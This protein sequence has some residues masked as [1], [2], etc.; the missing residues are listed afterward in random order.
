M[1]AYSCRCSWQISSTPYEHG[2]P[3]GIK[4][5]KDDEYECDTDPEASDKRH[6]D[7]SSDDDYESPG[8]APDSPDAGTKTSSIIDQRPMQEKRKLPMSVRLAKTKEQIR[9]KYEAYKREK[10]EKRREKQKK[11]LHDVE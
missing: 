1:Y 2:T 4:K 8:L 7:D 10:D 6:G 3:D 5:K 11:K 9:E